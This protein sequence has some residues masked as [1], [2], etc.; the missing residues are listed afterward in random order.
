MWRQAPIT[1]S[2]VVAGGL[3][4]H[5]KMHGMQ[6]GLKRVIEVLLGCVVGLVVT[7]MMSKLWSSSRTELDR[8]SVDGTEL[9][10]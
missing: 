7:F 2:I 5:T 4:T 9:P 8:S 3:G 10:R 6:E 1:A